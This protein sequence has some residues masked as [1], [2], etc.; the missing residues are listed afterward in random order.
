MTERKKVE[1]SHDRFEDM[2]MTASA[3][4]NNLYRVLKDGVYAGTAALVGAKIPL[5][6]ADAKAWVES[7]HLAH[8]SQPEKR[9]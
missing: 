2:D 4:T 1:Q 6:E 5:T 9:K 3:V 8:D 7:G